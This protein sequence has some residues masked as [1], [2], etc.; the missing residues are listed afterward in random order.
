MLLKHWCC[1]CNGVLILLMCWCTDPADVLT[2]LIRWACWYADTLILLMRWSC[3]CTDPAGALMLLMLLNQ[4]QDLSAAICSSFQLKHLSLFCA[5]APDSGASNEC[6]FL[7]S[8]FFS[9]SSFKQSGSF[10]IAQ[11]H[12]FII[13]NSYTILHRKHALIMSSQDGFCLSF[14]ITLFAF[15]EFL[16]DEGFFASKN[17]L[18]SRFYGHRAMFV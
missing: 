7:A 14:I 10:Q 4:D 2:L 8:F 18:L 3:W 13:H 9:P 6:R 12:L 5:R 11:Y 17:C 16:S 15:F 1:W